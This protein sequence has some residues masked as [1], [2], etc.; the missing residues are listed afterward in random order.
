MEK[1][2]IRQ[3]DIA[4]LAPRNMDEVKIA[5]DQLKSGSPLIINTT[6]LNQEEKLWAVHFLNGAIYALNGTVHELSLKV[7]LFAPPNIEV[8]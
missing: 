8:N 7:F 4:T 2:F 1:R 6:N 5:A 3:I